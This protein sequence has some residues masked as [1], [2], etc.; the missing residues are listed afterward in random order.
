MTTRPGT[1]PASSPF[2]ARCFLG[3]LCKLV[4]PI[5]SVFML[6][7]CSG[8]LSVIGLGDGD[9]EPSLEERVTLQEQKLQQHLDMF[10]PQSETPDDLKVAI[11]KVV[12]DFNKV[13]ERL[14]VAE[15]DAAM[16]EEDA[17]A[18]EAANRV[19]APTGYTS[20]G[21]ALD[22]GEPFDRSAIDIPLFQGEAGLHLVSY[23]DAANL[24]SG[25]DYFRRTYPDIL[26]VMD[27]RVEYITRMD[28][29]PF[30]RLKAGPLPSPQQA[31]P[32]CARLKARGA[33]CAIVPFTGNPISTFLIP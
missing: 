8:G 22:G 26:G 31:A 29:T 32:Y 1:N 17:A 4:A 15:I 13:A 20:A 3:C 33:F 5:G 23:S 9:K 19:Q 28:G 12:R 11:M 16:A 7:G 14:G 30:L 24:Q 25:W 10:E 21:A 6:A 18:K 27:V 2:K